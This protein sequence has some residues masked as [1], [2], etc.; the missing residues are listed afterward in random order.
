[1]YKYRIMDEAIMINDKRTIQEFRKSTFSGFKKT[2]AKKEL[3]NSLIQGNIES[4]NFWCAQLICSAHFLDIWDNILSFSCKHIHYGN[5]KLP[6]YL[7]TRFNTF[8]NIMN[9]GYI[10]N[11]LKLRN[12]QKIRDLFGEMICV[13]CL[14]QK[15]HTFDVIKI[16]DKDYSTVELNYKLKADKL[17]YAQSI[18]MDEDPKE[19]FV[20][21]N[22][23][24]YSIKKNIQHSSDAYYWIEWIMGYEKLSKKKKEKCQGT[25]RP[26]YPVDD[27]FQNDIIWIMWDIIIIE[28][29][30]RDKLRQ[31]IISSLKRLYC[32]KYKTSS[33]IKRRFLLYYAIMLLTENIDLRI[34]IVE[35]GETVHNIVNK[36]NSIY[37]QLKKDEIRPETD[38]LFHGLKKDEMD[39]TIDKLDMINNVDFIPRN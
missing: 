23:F 25:R 12:N 16:N 31:K 6:I 29:N 21:V 38:Y 33:K 14:S 26:N 11:E 35:S 24:A 4:A 9:S 7:D 18:F 37:K 13:L 22:E 32:L 5:P 10:D 28:A 39:K 20:P 15:K 2:S 27:K 19:L 8:K 30:T 17:I 34:P 3:L 36:V 1:M